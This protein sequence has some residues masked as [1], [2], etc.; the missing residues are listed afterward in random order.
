M[1]KMLLLFAIPFYL[2]ACSSS[3]ELKK[4]PEIKDPKIVEA[5]VN[6]YK[7]LPHD[8]TNTILWGILSKTEA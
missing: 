4:Y 3:N 2:F 5:M 1:K 8:S 7:K 6:H